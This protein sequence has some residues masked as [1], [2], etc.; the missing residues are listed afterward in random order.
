[1]HLVLNRQFFEEQSQAVPQEGIQQTRSLIDEMDAIQQLPPGDARTRRQ[2]E[3]SARINALNTASN[4]E[5]KK[6]VRLDVQLKHDGDELLV[7]CTIIHPLA[8]AYIR[9]EAKRTVERLDSDVSEVRDRQA[10]AID[11]ARRRKER[12]YIPLVY[13]LKKQP[14]RTAT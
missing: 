12:A 10:A 7:D 9:A 5:K 1:M 11:T 8:K 14:G 3:V 6:A 2:R 13:V 4:S